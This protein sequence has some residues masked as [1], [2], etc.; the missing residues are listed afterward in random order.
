MK[1]TLCV[2]LVLV[3]ALTLFAC[4][5][6]TAPVEAT[7]APVEATTAPE[8]ATEA[9]AKET[10]ILVF[11]AASMTEA[12]TE[13]QAAYKAIA[14]NV[15]IEYNFDSSGTL[16]TQIK[17][18]A[19]CDVFISAGQ[20]QMNALDVNADESANA[21]KTDMLLADSR[22]NI[23]SN[24][25]VLIVPEGAETEIAAFE[26]AL[27]SKVTL[28]ALG[29]SDVP[30]GQYAEEVYTS[31]GL[32]DEL[33]ASGKVSYGGNV[34]EVLSQVEAASVDCGVVYSTDAATASGVRVVCGAP[35][36]THKAIV[37]PAAILKQASDME[38]T[39][40]FVE[41]LKSDACSAV[42]ES[43]GFLIPER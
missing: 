43:I 18:G 30:A 16:L 12:L 7:T 1:K 31:L 42:F 21:D 40:A 23:V 5:P 3:M 13:I 34:K 39:L 33:V 17:E 37:Y 9:P 28:I 20:K 35:A 24:E 10:T 19:D 41:Y 15:T 36:G 8:Q 22:F 26:D 25:V 27:T 38:A 11:A 2:F 4:K 6:A 32:W 14:P 29:N